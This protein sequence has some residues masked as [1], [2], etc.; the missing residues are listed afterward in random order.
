M[1]TSNSVETDNILL[2]PIL[3]DNRV[4]LGVKEEYH[5]Q[6]LGVG[7]YRVT[8]LESDKL[9]HLQ[10]IQHH[11]VME[12]RECV[13]VHNCYAEGGITAVLIVTEPFKIRK[14]SV[15]CH[16]AC[17]QPQRFEVPVEVHASTMDATVDEKEEEEEEEEEELAP[18]PD[19]TTFAAFDLKREPRKVS[20]FDKFI[21]N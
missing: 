9:D 4:T 18:V 10:H 2:Y 15:L 6:K 7:A 14:D 8:I 11:V 17:P 12:R 16:F 20:V 3:D 1:M 21:Q 19:S 5:L 13:L